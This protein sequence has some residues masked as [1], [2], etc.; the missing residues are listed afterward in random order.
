MGEYSGPCSCS[1]TL[2]SILSPSPTGRK[3]VVRLGS[4]GNAP[5]TPPVTVLL[6]GVE[7]KTA[8]LANRSWAFPEG[9]S[10]AHAADSLW[11][12]GD[13][14]I[15]KVIHC[16]FNPSNSIGTASVLRLGVLSA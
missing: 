4:L 8:A 16:L 13:V 3:L 14:R 12:T 15:G 6:A 11:V 9:V 7:N 1:S 10:F 5:D 2:T